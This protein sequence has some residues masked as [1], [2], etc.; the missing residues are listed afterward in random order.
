MRNR[1]ILIFVVLLGLLLSISQPTLAHVEDEGGFL[2]GW[3]SLENFDD[4]NQVLEDN[5]YA[6]LSSGFFTFGGWGPLAYFDSVRLG[7]GGA[8]GESKSQKVDK[9]ARLEFGYGM[10][11]LAYSLF[12]SD[13]SVVTIGVGA[14]AGGTTLTLNSNRPSSFEDAIQNPTSTEL[15]RY[16]AGAKPYVSLRFDSDVLKMQI[17]GAYLYTFPDRWELRDNRFEGPPIDLNG[18]SVEVGLHIELD[19]PDFDYDF[20]DHDKKDEETEEESDADAS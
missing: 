17:I 12:R 1:S 4:F 15:N 18:W 20:P 19:L 7:F 14:I 8:S 16:F 13:I 2:A 6:P 9:K 11:D 5:D 10:L 3:I